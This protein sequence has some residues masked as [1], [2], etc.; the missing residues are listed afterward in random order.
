MYTLTWYPG[1][2][3]EPVTVPLR[4]ITSNDLLTAAADCDMPCSWFTDL[5]LYRTLYAVSYQLVV[6]ADAEVS[7]PENGMLMVVPRA[8]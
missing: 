2:G 4:D 8:L 5:F 6:G 1:D 3:A 7:L